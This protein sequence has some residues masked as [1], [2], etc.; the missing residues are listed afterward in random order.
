MVV[1]ALVVAALSAGAVVVV[2]LDI[3]AW[4]TS[5]DPS[6]PASADIES[7]LRL[8]TAAV[9]FIAAILWA[10]WLW[11]ALRVVEQRARLR[12]DPALTVTLL[13]V[14]AVTWVTTRRALD[15][16]W[17][18]PAGS[19]PAGG[20]SLGLRAWWPMVVVFT[21][22]AAVAAGLGVAAA[23]AAYI[24]DQLSSYRADAVAYGLGVPAALLGAVVTWQLS[25][26]AQVVSRDAVPVAVSV[27]RDPASTAAGRASLAARAMGW[28]A[29]GT[30]ALAGLYG[31]LTMWAL[32]GEPS[33]EAVAGAELGV[34]APAA[35]ALLVPV[36][37]WLWWF[38]A[39][40]A[41]HRVVH[42]GS[43]PG[44]VTAAWFLPPFC[45]FVPWRALARLL[46]AAGHRGRE[47]VVA[48]STWSVSALVIVVPTVS[49]VS[50]T[51]AP[52]A[53]SWYG[54]ATLAS[55]ALA[56][57]AAHALR[58]ITRDLAATPSPTPGP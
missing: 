29:W 42:G 6:P 8:T 17:R 35:F 31:V 33:Q 36:A 37:L 22:A 44:W 45:F 38:H 21:V 3:L 50:E 48:W 10:V 30:A 12:M 53:W 20:T 18:A 49:A 1:S 26:R 46:A 15:D 55:Y 51:P 2:T 32:L 14:P 13:F 28:L 7:Q 4:A 24:E 23:E 58:S 25:R 16:L 47:L 43:S 9:W 41:A 27:V 19:S 39:A 11:C 5:D 56:A 40:V 34:A 52:S 57:I 54:T